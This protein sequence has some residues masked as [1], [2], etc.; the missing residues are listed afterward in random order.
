MADRC[1]RRCTKVEDLCVYCDVN[2]KSFEQCC[3]K[4]AAERVPG[5]VFCVVFGDE[6]FVVD[7]G[8]FADFRV[9]CEE[10]IV[11]FVNPLVFCWLHSLPL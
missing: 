5:S 8:S 10:F 3:S 7:P 6:L 1:S 11:F 4:F 9:L 2:G